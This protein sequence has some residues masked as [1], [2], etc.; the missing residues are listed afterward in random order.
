M[1]MASSAER[2]ARIGGDAPIDRLLRS[3][4]SIAHPHVARLAAAELGDGLGHDLVDAVHFFCLVHG[5]FP[6]VMDNA[7]DRAFEPEAR[8]WMYR[9]AAG[10][11]AER[12]FLTRLTMI[13]G[14][15]PSTIGQARSEAA[16]EHQMQALSVLSRSE[17]RGTAIGSAIAL[18]LDWTA[19]R[20][21]LDKAAL[22]FGTVTPPLDLPG[23]PDTMTMIDAITS[24]PGHS[25]AMMF[26]SQQL[27]VQHRGLWDLLQVRANARRVG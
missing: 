17:R 21:V 4:G 2:I 6:G 24:G 7:A 15:M 9:A 10:F 25:R 11:S 18:A 20:M 8:A 1:G 23:L 19:V 26:G 16:A 22:R 3:D 13:V 5:R 27:L 12:A 14:P